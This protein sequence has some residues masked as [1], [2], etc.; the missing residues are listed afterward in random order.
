MTPNDAWLEPRGSRRLAIAVGAGA[1]LLAAGVLSS[2]L[3]RPSM[4]HVPSTLAGVKLESTLDEARRALPALERV[5][6]SEY[7]ART[8]VF[9]EPAT[10]GLVLTD[11]SRV[12][13]IDCLVDPRDV[14][15]R[16]RLL[17]TLRALYGEE[18][19]TPQ[20]VWRWQNHRARLDLT[21]A[22]DAARI[23]LRTRAP[24]A[25]SASSR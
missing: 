11:G 13:S 25:V 18:S 5:G 22:A 7:R 17:V 8:V 14:R 23:S 16:E 9:D 15:V 10:C 1:A 12:A 19:S 20:D 6:A 2:K 21:A 4:A 24:E 3:V